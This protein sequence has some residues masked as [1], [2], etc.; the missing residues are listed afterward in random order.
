[1]VSVHIIG[2][3]CSKLIDQMPYRRINNMRGCLLRL[4]VTEQTL[5]P[6]VF[7]HDIDTFLGRRVR[8]LYHNQRHRG[9][10]VICALSNILANREGA[11][12]T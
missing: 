1:M 2:L 4:C 8:A 5:A 7:P 12:R 11:R 6:W 10:H 9:G 3:L